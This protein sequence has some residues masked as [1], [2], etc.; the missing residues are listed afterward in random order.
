MSG[1]ILL[2]WP[3]TTYQA[4]D[5]LAAAKRA[6]VKVLIGSDRCHEIAKLWPT[7]QEPYYQAVPL[8][9]RDLDAAVEQIRALS[10]SAVIP[11]D[12]HTSVLAAKAAAA[13]GLSAN[14]P[15]AAA[16]ARNKKLLREALSAAGVP[17]PKWRAFPIESDP[18]HL[19]VGF[20]CVVKPLFLS[21]SRG[22]IRANDRQALAAA[23]TRT[24]A[25]VRTPELAAKAP[26]A[27]GELLIEEFVPGFEVALEGML[28][29]GELR[30]LA[31]FDKPDPLEGP[32]FEETIYVTPS[33]LPP[34]TQDAIVDCAA[35]GARALGLR[36][37]PVHAEL[38]ITPTSPVV[39]EIAARSIG[40]LCSRTLRFGA[41]LSLEDLIVAHA[42]G[43][44]VDTPRERAASG[45][46]MLPIP[47][48]GVLR[49]VRGQTL[50]AQVPGVTGIEITALLGHEVVPLPEGASYL[51]FLF[52]RGEGPAFVE[53]ALREAYAKLAVD[54]TPVLPVA[55]GGLP[56]PGGDAL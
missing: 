9:F 28:A 54:I 55:G 23:W 3:K 18:M 30:P 44:N 41:G 8:D 45:V 2:L 52:A 43:R 26:E 5:F 48:R 6:G 19:D 7:G 21:M 11:T 53:A 32:F 33:R 15:R 13:L 50:A 56:A 36:E 25:L 39:L 12:D 46:M 35:R 38:R 31:I 49:E 42:L 34:A 16:A 24:A 14:P 4:E 40:G 51:G 1:R 29:S 47:R 17:V 37:G 22:V 27:A 20:P 10:P